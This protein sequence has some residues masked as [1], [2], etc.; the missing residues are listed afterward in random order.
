MKFISIF[1]FLIKLSHSFSHQIEPHTATLS[2]SAVFKNF[3]EIEEIKCRLCQKSLFLNNFAK[4]LYFQHH[5]EQNTAN[6]ACFCIEV[7]LQK[8]IKKTCHLCQ[9]GVFL[10]KLSHIQLNLAFLLYWRIFRKLTKTCHLGQKSVF[11]I[12][13]SHIQLHLAF[14]L[15]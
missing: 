15:F 4:Y 6:E 8:L 12:K 9:K 5:N 3:T 11:L 10:I 1:F 14:L 13:L 2:F 7:F